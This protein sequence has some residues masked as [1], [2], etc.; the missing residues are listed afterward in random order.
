VIWTGTCGFGRRQAD[1]ARELDTVEI[2]ETF[3][4]PVSTERAKRW[5]AVAPPGFRFCVKASQFITHEAT[6]PTYRRSGR[7]VSEPEKSGYGGFKDTPQVREGWESTRAV[8][9]ELSAQAIVFQTPSTFGPTEANRNAVYR[10]FESIRTEAQRA[11]ELRGPWAT[12]IVQRICEDLG[13]VHAV[14][15][16]GSEPATYGLAYFRLHGSPPGKT[17]YRY[18][19]T[20]EDLSRLEEICAEYDDAYVMFNTITMHQDAIRFAARVRQGRP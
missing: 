7:V 9:E 6:S 2:Q 16:F 18:S 11:I 12:H 19:Y 5:R 17:M 20:D 1:V 8:A 4:R 3:Y 14:D 13:L 15:P 10:F